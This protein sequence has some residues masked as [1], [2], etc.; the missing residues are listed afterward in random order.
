MT[1]KVS[2]KEF[3]QIT[4]DKESFKAQ[5]RD[6]RILLSDNLELRERENIKPFFEERK[7][8]SA[9]IGSR[10]FPGFVKPDRIAFEYDLFGDFRCDLV[11]GNSTNRQYCFVEFEDGTKDSI[12]RSTHRSTL[13]WAPRFEHG[14]SQIVDWF[15]KLDDMRTTTDFKD[16]FD[17][18]NIQ[19][20]GQLVIGR[21]QWLD[22]KQFR[23]LNWRLE[24]VVVDSRPVNCITFDQLCTELE[25][26]LREFEIT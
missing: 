23:R 20:F 24:H 4:F 10:C 21:D 9:L 26:Q 17:S 12:F 22:P 6:F 13:E 1:G 7:Q 19:Y 16:R 18:D 15:H 5:L 2:K 14:F 25:H 8:L 3:E 11:V